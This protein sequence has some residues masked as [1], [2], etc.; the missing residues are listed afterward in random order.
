MPGWKTSIAGIDSWAKLP[1]KAKAYV[2]RIETL[3]EVP[4]VIVSTGPDR[5]HTIQLSPIF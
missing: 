1:D 4:V 2:K 3:L 5:K